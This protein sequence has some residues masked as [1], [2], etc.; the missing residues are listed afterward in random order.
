MVV[1]RLLGNALDAAMSDVWKNSL[2]ASR[3]GTVFLLCSVYF[4]TSLWR[5]H[6]LPNPAWYEMLSLSTISHRHRVAVN[7]S[8]QC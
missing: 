6:L 1:Q 3:R 2:L 5:S 8:S 7:H 4:L